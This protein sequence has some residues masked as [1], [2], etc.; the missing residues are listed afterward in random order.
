MSGAARAAW[1]AEADLGTG[2]GLRHTV[3]A[4]P[5]PAAV[6]LAASPRA[7]RAGVPLGAHVFLLPAVP[8]R[9]AATTTGVA[10]DRTCGSVGT[11]DAGVC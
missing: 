4:V 5:V 10:V 1:S 9:P 3:L 11:A 7:S 6:P 8:S 2:R